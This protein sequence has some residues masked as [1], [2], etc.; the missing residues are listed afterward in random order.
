MK[1]R[2]LLRVLVGAGT[3]ALSPD[4]FAAAFEGDGPDE[5]RLN[6]AAQEASDLI[7]SPGQ[8]LEWLRMG[9]VKP[10]G[11][12]KD[13]MLRD[14]RVGFAGCL[15]KL[16]HE[17]DSD[18]FVTNRNSVSKVN[19]GNQ[20][21]VNWWNGE[22][23]GNWRAGHI[24]MAYLAEDDASMKEADRY[25]KHILASQ[26]SDGYL[27]I[28]EADSRFGNVGELWTQACLF[29]GLLA[30][31]EMTSRTDVFDAVRRAVDL[32]VNAYTT[33]GKTLPTG[34]SHDLMFSDVLERLSTL[35]GETKY[36]DF[37]LKYYEY[38]GT[39]DPTRDDSLTSLLNPDKPFVDHGVRTYE[40]IRV[41]LWLGVSTGRKDLRQAT[42]N[43]FAKM[44]R[45]SEPGGSGVSQEAIENQPPDPS[46]TEY[47]YCSTKELQCTFASAMQKT[48]RAE[49]GD[50]IEKI[51]FNAAQ[52]SRLPDGSA[53][54]YLTSDNCSRIDKTALSGKGEEPRNK[55]SPTHAD[56]AV[57]CNP[58][59]T[60]VAAQFVRSMWMRHPKGGLV[61]SLY[62]PST[63][64]TKVNGA[65][66]SLDER[67]RYPFENTVEMHVRSDSADAFPLYLRNPEWSKKTRVVCDG[68]SISREG[69][70][71]RV[72]KRWK[73]G[74]TVRIEFT[75]EVQEIPAVNGE[76]AIQYGALA[77]AKPLPSERKAIKK[78]EVDRFE[79]TVY[80]PLPNGENDLSLPAGQLAKAFQP[81]VV[82]PEKTSEH[83]F[84]SPWVELHGHFV[85]ST[86][87]SEAATLVP[88]GNAPTLRRITF[89]VSHSTPGGESKKAELA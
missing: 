41:P 7:L 15:D 59:A 16:C 52:G 64:S 53:V 85:R 13:Q 44:F 4:A 71:W 46:R 68:A 39:K 12:I 63:L 19:N 83:P 8:P 1:R 34:D 78:Y 37:A 72:L 42:T 6:K 75:P 70:Y 31:Y 43:A 5:S 14:L 55:Y 36:R 29:R 86:G 67:T 54:T 74:D 49:F 79:D 65:A 47:E 80:T 23:E 32:T 50:R 87:A 3:I 18:I 61:A 76:V 57:C 60:Q 82:K 66:F 35:T 77:F 30:Y 48:G 88:L 20:N 56:V 26:D 62:G 9:E 89:P 81:V 24:M 27:G 84:D 45:Y 17:A 69:S 11:W 22:T 25:V 38:W 40:N 10:S 2:D 33:G 21:S 58:N 73:S 51:W 28:F